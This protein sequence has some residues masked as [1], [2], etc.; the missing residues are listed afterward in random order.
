MVVETVDRVNDSTAAANDTAATCCQIVEMRRK[1][2]APNASPN[3]ICVT[4]RLGNGLTSWSDPDEEVSVCHPGNVES[5]TT[6]AKQSTRAIIL[7]PG[8]H[9]R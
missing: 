6:T 4:S 5:K 2:D 3:A 7:F 1:T 9:R 8:K